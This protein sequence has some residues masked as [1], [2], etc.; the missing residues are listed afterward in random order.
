MTEHERVARCQGDLLPHVVDRLARE[1]PNAKYG[2]WATES[3][4]VTITYAQLA[5]AINGLAGWLV[6]QLGP[7][8]YGTHPDVL[9]YV[10]PNDARYSALVLAAIKT[11]YVLFVTSPRN[12]SAAHRALFSHLQCRTFI[13]TDPVPAP[14]RAILDAV[15]S[16]SSLTVPPLEELLTKKYPFYVLNKSFKDLRRNPFVV[17]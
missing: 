4:V 17:M 5:N 1:R 12:S 13:T 3:N 6:E 8:R 16:L 2:E 11:G 7:G 9:T 14:A 10:G 15:K